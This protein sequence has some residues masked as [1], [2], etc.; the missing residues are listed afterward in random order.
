MKT[1]LVG[2]NRSLATGITK[3]LDHPFSDNYL[4]LLYKITSN[5]KEGR[6]KIQSFTL[7]MYK[8]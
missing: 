4:A 2:T 5:M 7:L 1:P 6:L 3:L 8:Y